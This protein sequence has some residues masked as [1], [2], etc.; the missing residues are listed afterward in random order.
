MF[1]IDRN[2]PGSSKGSNR[3]PGLQPSPSHA[4]LDWREMLARAR[5]SAEAEAAAQ[6]GPAMVTDTF[7]L[8]LRI[9]RSVGLSPM[10]VLREHTSRT[11]PA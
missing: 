9:E 7:R 5:A 2:S 8:G 4:A 1:Q 10:D 11:T 3:E 6:G